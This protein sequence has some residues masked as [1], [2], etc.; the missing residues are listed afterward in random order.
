MAIQRAPGS[1]PVFCQPEAEEQPEPLDPS[2]RDRLVAENETLRIELS[3]LR[4]L[5]KMTPVRVDS[6]SLYQC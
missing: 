4:S 1:R 3:Q 2:E 6:G 5:L